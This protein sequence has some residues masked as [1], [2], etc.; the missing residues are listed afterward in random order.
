MERESEVTG[1]FIAESEEASQG[2]DKEARRD[3]ERVRMTENKR[4][5]RGKYRV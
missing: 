5:V 3:T 4:Q 1:E 2:I